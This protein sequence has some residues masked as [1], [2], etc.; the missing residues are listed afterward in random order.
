MRLWLCALCWLPLAHA[1]QPIP[2]LS[3]RVMDLTGTLSPAERADIERRLADLERR[4]GTQIAVLIVSTTQPETIEQ[5]AR[6]VLDQWKLGRK[7]ID[8]GALLLVAKDDR[9]LRIETQ[10]GLEGVIPDAVAKRIIEEDIVPHLRAG[11]FA[12]GIRAGVER[13]VALVEGE[14]LPPPKPPQRDGGF[15]ELLPVLAFVVLFAGRL[16]GALFGQL[17]GATLGAVLAGGLVWLSLGSLLLGLAVGFVVFVLLLATLGG[18]GGWGGLG[19]GWSS[20][21]GFGGGG[22]SGGGG[23][24]GGGGASGRW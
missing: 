21:G 12:G 14:P 1:Q 18:G 6:R 24:G 7:G 4:K 11:D 5:Y 2:P 10:Y 15:G 9:R 17:L 13:M 8:D 3:A 20:G 23:M 16:L 22:F 19:G